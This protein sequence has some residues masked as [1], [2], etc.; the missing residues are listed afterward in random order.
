MTTADFPK[1]RFFQ[2]IQNISGKGIARIEEFG[3]TRVFRKI[4]METGITSNN[5]TQVK[6]AWCGGAGKWSIASGNYASCVVC[7]G[8]GLV[9]VTGRPR[10]CW[11]CRGKGK[12]N[13]VSPCL[14]CA[15][16]GWEMVLGQ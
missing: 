1:I 8:K 5:N 13:G 2:I 4:P 7:D 10:E 16:T 15:G 9:S 3:M 6:C 12:I 14:I 11:Q